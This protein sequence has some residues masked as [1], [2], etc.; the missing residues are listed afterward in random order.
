MTTTVS[1]T[2]AGPQR[3]SSDASMAVLSERLDQLTRVIDSLNV[4]LDRLD[5]TFVR[6]DVYKADVAAMKGAVADVRE[7]VGAIR[8]SLTWGWR[9]I[10]T[11]IGT[12]VI[13]AA[14]GVL[15][16]LAGVHK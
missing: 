13:M 3:R 7:D 6:Q 1:P 4:R 8:R 2:P 11:L 10:G 9:T 12:F 14:S 16:A 5:T 15:V